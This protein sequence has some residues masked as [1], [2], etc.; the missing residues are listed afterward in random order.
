MHETFGVSNTK[1]P[2]CAKSRVDSSETPRADRTGKEKEG[3]WS[4]R[5]PCSPGRNNGVDFLGKYRLAEC[6][7]RSGALLE[8]ETSSGQSVHKIVGT[9]CAIEK[10]EEDALLHVC[11]H[12]E[13]PPER[14]SIA[15]A[16]RIVLLKNSIFS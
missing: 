1:A 13:L 10:C 3:T 11:V 12:A 16:S 2:K 5:A 7:L 6:A 15:R 4:A 9:V 8:I 14:V